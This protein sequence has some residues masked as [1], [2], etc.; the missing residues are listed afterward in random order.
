MAK[1]TKTKEYTVCDIC[2]TGVEP[3]KYIMIFGMYNYDFCL[4]C[5]NG[6]IDVVRF[7]KTRVGYDI[8]YQ[9]KND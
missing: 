5:F 6:T 4:R 9:V 3:G 7:L 1:K 2:G 8:I